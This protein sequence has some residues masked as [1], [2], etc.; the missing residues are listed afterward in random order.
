MLQ[1]FHY[2]HLQSAKSKDNPFSLRLKLDEIFVLQ[3]CYP[4]QMHAMFKNCCL[5]TDNEVVPRC[6]SGKT[7]CNILVKAAKQS[8]ILCPRHSKTEPIEFRGAFIIST[9]TN[10]FTVY[11][12]SMFFHYTNITKHY[13][14]SKE[15]M[16]QKLLAFCIVLF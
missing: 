10:V 15:I 3:I 9:T 11:V 14:C 5:Y 16:Q 13:G 7:F 12:K 4:Y 1:F 6:S 8:I 2:N